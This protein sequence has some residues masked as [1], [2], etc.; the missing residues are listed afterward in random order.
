MHYLSSI[1]IENFK[2]IKKANFS[3]K[4]YTP[5]VGYNNA[6]KSN[7]ISAIK[8]LLNTSSL[9]ESFFN[10]PEN[11]IQIKGHIRGVT[12]EILELLKDSHKN[13]IEKYVE[14]NSIRIKRV[15]PTPNAPRAQQLLFIWC[16]IENDWK[17]NPTGIDAALKAMFPETIEVEA[18]IDAAEDVSKQKASNTI[19]KLINAMLSTVKENH[20]NDVNSAL[21]GIKEKFDADGKN[22]AEELSDFDE[23]VT[24]KLQLIFPGI[25]IKLHVPTPDIEGIFKSATLKL[26][27]NGIGR[28]FADYGHGTQRSVQMALIRELAEKK[29]KTEGTRATT[30]LLIDEPE[31]YL[32][33]QA[34]EQ[35]RA[36][37]K[38]L[39][40]H[41]YQVVFSTHSPQMIPAED[42]KNTLLIKKCEDG[43][44]ARK[45]IKQAVSEVE[46]NHSSQYQLLF[47][48][49]NA[50]QILFSESVVLT[51]GLTEKR[52]LPIIYE[53]HTKQTFGQSKIALVAQGSVDNTINAMNV[54]TTMGIPCKAIV[55]LDFAFRGTIKG[56]LIEKECPDII[57]CKQVLS[58]ASNC[59]VLD[60]NQLPKKGGN[61]SPAEAFEWLA[62]QK[63][64]MAPI[65]RL[66]DKLLDR[67]IWLWKRGAI[68]SYLG[69]SG[70][71]EST[72]AVLK[73]RIEEENLENIITCQEFYEM[74]NWLNKSG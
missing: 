28:P 5:I 34:I 54:L 32:H 73:K 55:D 19:G 8:W 42:V 26:F 57:E 6:G 1:E 47:S 23:A 22:R 13:R 7:I 71:N 24:E 64:A 33:P 29:N 52:L 67:N 14:D 27:E 61:K 39:S 25:E 31:L 74:L 11:P 18:M 60:D 56:G 46:R 16:P 3:L 70:K 66:H 65:Q 40:K 30:L 68:E 50:S 4:K 21:E 43:T 45:T 44:K 35:V 48:L 2:S 15:Q 36:S 20:L 59:I 17:K 58:S 62:T 63:E 9:D 41:G 38:R 51:E 37:L 49:E 10:N 72:W 12:E 69:I 53:A